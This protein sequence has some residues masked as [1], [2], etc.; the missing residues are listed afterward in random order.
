MVAKLKAAYLSLQREDA[1]PY[2]ESGSSM[3]IQVALLNASATEDMLV[4]VINVTQLMR[5]NPLTSVPPELLMIGRVFGLLNGLSKTLQA[6]TNML[7]AFAQ[8]A[9]EMQAAG[10]IDG[11][12]P[13]AAS[14]ARRLLDS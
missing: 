1:P 7:F 5:R 11:A 9:D 10:T 8:L 14:G 4:K 2:K 13:A 3:T 6:R 12:A